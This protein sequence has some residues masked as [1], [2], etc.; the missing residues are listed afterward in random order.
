MPTVTFRCSRELKDWLDR[1]CEKI[2][3]PKGKR[4]R[5]GNLTA[6]ISGLLESYRTQNK[7]V[8]PVQQN[9]IDF[10]QWMKKL[11]P[12]NRGLVLAV[13]EAASGRTI[14]MIYKTSPER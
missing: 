1:E 10:G 5:P 7:Y 11:T 4:G 2:P 8:V 12:A 14:G 9:V 13:G 3:K 6:V